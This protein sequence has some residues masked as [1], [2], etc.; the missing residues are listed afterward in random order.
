MSPQ[1]GAAELL[2]IGAMVSV[3]RWNR[4]S[5]ATVS[6]AFA[7]V[8]SPLIVSADVAA[9]VKDFKDILNDITLTP[10]GTALIR[11]NSTPRNTSNIEQQ[12]KQNIHRTR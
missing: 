3:V 6:V 7:W 9:Q 8:D 4:Q 11:A 10:Y 12:H 5:G 2:K 1:N